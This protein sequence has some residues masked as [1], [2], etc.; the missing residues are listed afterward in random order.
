MAM[1]KIQQFRVNQ[2]SSEY[3]PAKIW[4]NVGYAT[5]DAFV[6]LPFG[7][8]LDTM[9]K[10]EPK[11]QSDFAMLQAAQND[12]LEQ[13]LSKA[14]ELKPGE[15]EVFTLQVQLRRTADE[16][17]PEGNNKFLKKLF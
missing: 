10:L 16:S 15:A 12:L 17:K 2:S 14:E 1:G 9:R 11:G 13:L 3:Q 5:D 7:L 6:S 4:L 8:A